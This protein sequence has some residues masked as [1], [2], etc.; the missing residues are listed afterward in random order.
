MVQQGRETELTA[1]FQLN[2]EEKE[3][4]GTNFIPENMPKYVDMPGS[5]TFRNKK[6]HIRKQGF[7]IGRVHTV[8]PLAGDVFY[9]RMLL[10]NEHSKGKT[11]YQ[12]LL[13]IDGT[14]HDTYQSVCRQIGLLS[15]DQEWSLVLTEAGGTQMCPQIRALYIVILLFCQPSNPKILF[16]DFWQDWTDDFKQKGLRRG[17]TFTD[18][19]LK[20]MV[21]LDLQ[22]CIVIK[23]I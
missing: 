15:D 21:W 4:C 20:T 6:W 5:Y 2:A 8:N 22:V 3:K 19:Q 16:E 10:H 12:D 1:F 14:T 23:I 17:Y 7:S 13:T 11:S 18:E 9:L